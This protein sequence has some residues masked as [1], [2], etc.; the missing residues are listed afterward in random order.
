MTFMPVHMSTK[1]WGTY[2]GSK[3]QVL[4][5]LDS[6]KMLGVL[7]VFPFRLQRPPEIREGP[8]REIGGIIKPG[9]STHHTLILI[10]TLSIHSDVWNFFLIQ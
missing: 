4:R 3:Q 1:A 8:E 9:K 7:R 2:R 6:S 5:A 10:D